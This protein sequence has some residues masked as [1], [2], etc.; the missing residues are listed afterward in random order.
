MRFV[1]IN[2]VREGTYLAK[3]IYDDKGITLLKKGVILDKYLLNSIK[4][5]GI[6]SIYI[7]DEY[8]LNEIE[9]VIK[10]ELRQK[11]INSIKRTFEYFKK[12]NHMILES[13]DPKVREH[14]Y[15]KREEY[16]NNIV[17]IGQQM[18]DNIFENRDILI[19]LV[20][21]KSYDNYTYQHCVNVAILS[22]VLGIELKLS[23]DQLYN[24]CVGAMMHDVGKVMIPEKILKKKGTLTHDEYSEIQKHTIRGYE[25]LKTAF[26]I[27]PLAKIIALEHHER[28]D[29]KGYPNKMSDDQINK[30]AKIV[31]ISDVYD[32][33]TSDRPYR[34]AIPPNEA[35][36]YIM[37]SGGSMFEYDL[38]KIF[39]TRIIPFPVGSIVRL[40]SGDIGL[41][42][43]INPGYPLKP[44]VK[45]IGKG[46]KGEL[47]LLK[48]LN[49]VIEGPQYEVSA[50]DNKYEI[51]GI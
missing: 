14:A 19:N 20:D 46:K 44:I 27:P 41:V 25:Y 13:T 16:I 32:A 9:D 28:V 48:C 26:R 2:A 30:Y 49:I 22:T 24:L 34:E 4:R 31:A 7:N 47:D 43:E 8:S 17:D 45:L 23:K 29:G 39:S 11:A 12:Y 6:M 21:I 1:P 37:G 40:S 10:P 42:V 51:G 35:M 36:E 50:S 18:V 33:L 38:V 5:H 15:I 3:T